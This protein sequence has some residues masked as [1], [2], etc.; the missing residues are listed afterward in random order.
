MYIYLYICTP[1]TV[2]VFLKSRLATVFTTQL[3]AQ[4][5]CEFSRSLLPH[6]VEK[7]PMRLR[8]CCS[9]LQCVAVCCSVLQFVAVCCS[10]LQCVAVL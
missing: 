1:G 5:F 9:V 2:D 7:R 8:W 6:S 10:V 4:K 3:T